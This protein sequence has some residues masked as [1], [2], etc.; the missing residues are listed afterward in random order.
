VFP[1][2]WH[3]MDVNVVTQIFHH[4]SNDQQLLVVF[5]TKH[6]H[7]RIHQVEQASHDRDHAVKV[8]GAKPAFQHASK[9]RCGAK[10]DRVFKAERVNRLHVRSKKQVTT[11]LRQSNPVCFQRPGI[12][13]NILTFAKLG[14]I[15]IDTAYYLV[16]LIPGCFD[17]GQVARMEVAHRGNQS[18]PLSSLPPVTGTFPEFLPRFGFKHML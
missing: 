16:G 10:H 15:H 4:A 3:C 13:F 2:R 1:G 11:R 9:I 18:D 17:Q 6:G 5:F 12:T 8:P 7:I 14:G